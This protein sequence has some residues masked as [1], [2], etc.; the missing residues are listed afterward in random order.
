MRSV[1][2][3]T[4]CRVSISIIHNL[5]PMH[6]S[7]VLFLLLL[8]TLTTHFWIFKSMFGTSLTSYRSYIMR[9]VTVV[10]SRISSGLIFTTWLCMD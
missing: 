4:D 3:R 1:T 6:R 10:T 9:V 5:L 7:Q 2:V 8:M